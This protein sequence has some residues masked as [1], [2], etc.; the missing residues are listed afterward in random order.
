MS[1][2]EEKTP[3]H[4]VCASCAHAFVAAWLPM[5]MATLATVLGSMHCPMCGADA[6]HLKMC[7]APTVKEIE[8]NTATGRKR[9]S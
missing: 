3:M 1:G 8:K 2:K 9:G 5:P 4:V 6:K 7:D